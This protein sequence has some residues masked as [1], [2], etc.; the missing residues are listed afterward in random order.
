MQ[1]VVRSLLSLKTE[2]VLFEGAENNNQQGSDLNDG[3]VVVDIEEP[4]SRQASTG[5][6][7]EQAVILVTKT[8]AGPTAQLLSDM[9]SGIDCCNAVLLGMSGYRRYI[10]PPP[11]V[12]SEIGRASLGKSVSAV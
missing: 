9:R 6:I 1:A 3:D 11:E 5:T 12:S 10:G 4:R 8:L 2:T 7:E